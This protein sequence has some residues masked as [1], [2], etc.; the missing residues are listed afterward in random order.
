MAGL[1][2]AGPPMLSMTMA[3]WVI[4]KQAVNAKL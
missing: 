4:E 3:E 1:T 2:E